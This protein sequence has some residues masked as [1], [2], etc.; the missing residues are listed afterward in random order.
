MPST[1]AFPACS[2]C[3]YG[4]RSDG[5][6]DIHGTAVTNNL[7]CRTYR[8]A[9][10]GHRDARNRY[11]L[12]DQLRPGRVYSIKR[13]KT[14]A[15]QSVS[16]R[17]NI[18]PILREE[19][20]PRVGDTVLNSYSVKVRN[21]D[22]SECPGRFDCYE[23]GLVILAMADIR[24]GS[25]GSDDVFHALQQIRD[26]MEIDGRIPLVNGSNRHAIV[27]G[28]TRSMGGGYVVNLVSM[29][30]SHDGN[31]TA[32]TFGTDLVTDPVFVADQ[33]AFQEAWWR[34]QNQ[35]EHRA[36]EVIGSLNAALGAVIGALAGDAAGATL[37]FL[38]RKPTSAE[39]DLAMAMVGGGVWKTAPG[40]ITDDGE[41]TLALAH[42]LTGAPSYDPN[43]VAHWY[44]KW[45][46]SQPFDIGNA[47]TNALGSGDLHSSTLAELVTANARKFNYASKAN[48]GLMRLS[49]L[50]VWSTHLALG[51]AINAARTDA[52]LTHPHPSCQWAG[53]AYVVAI[54]HLILHPG[55]AQGAFSS[56]E[57]VVSESGVEEVKGWLSD[58]RTGSLPC[59][60]P[61]AG[62][63]RIG[64]THAFY[65]LH[66]QHSYEAGI[67]AVLSGGGDTDTNA[68][69]VGGLLGALHGANTLPGVMRD[70]VLNC[71]TQCG[72]PRPAW[73]HTTQ[74]EKLVS[75]LLL[76][77]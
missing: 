52:Q 57:A 36:A 67:S 22:G 24:Y 11:P 5:L 71:D 23:S 2:T 43:R 19:P 46:L 63:V 39:V 58:A 65:S 55:D 50:G 28:M 18:E 53:V 77:E 21:I 62:F 76:G 42:A 16:A 13:D 9:G 14:S 64:F 75:G 1:D 20:T 34:C 60:H 32:E 51:D 68:C 4:R 3:T 26:T 49:A 44:R 45:Y 48:G 29:E 8:N 59:F 7:V 72:R 12:L 6:C 37:E 69:I 33:E 73:L 66:Q 40:Q 61:N 27:S 35:S 47:T 15:G 41:L 74:V 70:R 38:G 31:V 54:R 10:Q 30:N 25:E 17:F 56:A